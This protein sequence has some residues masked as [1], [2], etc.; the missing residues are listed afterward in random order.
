M[1]DKRELAEEF[2]RGRRF[3]R[4][5]GAPF[6][7]G[8]APFGPWL[9]GARW[10]F[11]ISWFESYV[12]YER[13]VMANLRQLQR[14]RWLDRKHGQVTVPEAELD[15]LEEA[16]KRELREVR[17][18][19]DSEL[20][21]GRGRHGVVEAMRASPERPGS[22][23]EYGDLASFVRQDRRRAVGDWPRREDAGGADFGH[24]WQLENPF[25]RWQTTSWRISWLCQSGNGDEGTNEIYALEFVKSR[26]GTRSTGR[27][28]LLGKLS[29]LAAVEGALG[30]LQLYAMDERNS[31][32]AAAAAVAAAS[33]AEAGS[34]E[35]T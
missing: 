22:A 10:K 27:V 30:D 25:R 17:Q 16:I 34:A 20:A 23:V 1:A 11:K 13:E 9:P 33:R 29:T 15:R 12:E 24:R 18:A 4:Q 5:E 26:R 3:G 32:I 35:Q 7:G 31:L 21:E 2:E 14:T 19:V 8:I 6:E 28:W